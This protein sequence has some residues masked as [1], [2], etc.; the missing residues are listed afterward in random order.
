MSSLSHIRNFCIIAHIDHGKSTLADRMLDITGTVQKRLQRDQQLDAMDLERERGITIKSHPVAMN[1]TAPDG[2]KYLFHLIDTPGHVDF[3]YEVE[4]SLAACEG[5]LL[6]VDVAQ[7]VEAQTV[8]NSHLAVLQGLTIIPVFNKIDL[9]SSDIEGTRKQIED[10]LAIPAEDALNVSAKTGQGVAEILQAIVDRVPPPSGNPEGASRA[11]VFDSIYDT[12][13]GVVTY[14]RV[15]D[16]SFRAGEKIRMMATGQDYEIKEV[17]KF[18]PQPVPVK[19]LGA[20]EVGYIIANIKEPSDIRI[21]D[22]VTLARQPAEIPLPGFKEIH[23]MVF[24]GL[25]PIETSDYEKL[26]A[27]LD[28]LRLNDCSFVYQAESSVALGFGFRC[29]FLGLLHLEVIQERLRREYD[30]DLISTYPGVVYKVYLTS[31]EMIEVD[32]PVYL[33]ETNHIECIEEPIVK[34]SIICHNEH[35]GDMMQLIMDRRGTLEHTHSM[36][37]RRVML[38]CKL[39]LNEILLDFHDR[40]KSLSR[41]YSSMDYEHAGYEPSDLVKLDILV[42]GEV[43][44]AFSCIIHRSKAESRGREICKSLKEVIPSQMFQIPLQAAIGRNIIA[45][46]TIRAFRKDVT[47][48]CYGGDVSRKRKLLEKQKEGK[49]KMKLVGR[50]SIPQDAFVSVLRTDK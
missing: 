26:K 42:N 9:P 11:L 45:R 23:P 31:G 40:L 48:K 16:G 18:M 13:R 50:V 27:S 15:V 32:N 37:T 29:G 22:T 43:V 2:K 28:K 1:Y 3:T 14:I 49:K 4:R 20:G 38:T 30:L 36:D 10:V 19:I 34:A 46:E 39:P 5:A 47:A 24:A 8:A 33:P 7:G 44:D 21:G 41:G 17:G 6:V 12:F 35:I 25:Y